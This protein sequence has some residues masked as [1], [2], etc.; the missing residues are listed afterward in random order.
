MGNK[1]QKKSV[2]NGRGE[3]MKEREKI[4]TQSLSK[5]NRED[6]CTVCTTCEEASGESRG[7]RITGR[8][9]IVVKD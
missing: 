6:E 9:I 8:N 2:K 7:D 1:Y 5:G 4:A 3:G